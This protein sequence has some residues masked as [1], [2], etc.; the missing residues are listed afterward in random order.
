MPSHEVEL[1]YFEGCPHWQQT[2]ATIER[3]SSELRGETDIHLVKVRD[4]DAAVKARFL[5]SPTVRVDGRDIEP[6]AD[7]RQEY[8]FA[9]RVYKTAAGLSGQPDERWLHAALIGDD[10]R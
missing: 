2:R 3:V 7:D 1:L 6:G 4:P 8:V 10:Q 9:C 5:G